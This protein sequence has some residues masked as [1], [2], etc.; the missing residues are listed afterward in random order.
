MSTMNDTERELRELFVETAPRQAPERLRDAIQAGTA[1]LRQRPG[2]LARNRLPHAEPGS[3]RGAVGNQSA[4]LSGTSLRGRAVLIAATT[5]LATAAVGGA[6]FLAGG[7]DGTTTP[8]PTPA[9]SDLPTGTAQLLP[10]GDWLADVGPIPGIGE[11]SGRIHL[12][13]GMPPSTDA[14]IRRADGGYV[15]PSDI[16]SAGPAELRVRATGLAGCSKGDEGHYGF[17]RSADGL[18]LTLTLIEDA[19]APRASTFS[20]TWARSHGAEN[21]GGLGILSAF[22]PAIQVGLPR[23][24]WAVAGVLANETG[25]PMAVELRELGGMTLIAVKNPSGLADP[26]RPE[27]RT[28]VAVTVPVAPTIAAFAAYLSTLPGVA[29][30]TEDGVVGG[31]ATRHVSVTTDRGTSCP[32]QAVAAFAAH[33]TQ[34][35]YWSIGAGDTESIWLVEVGEDLYLLAFRQATPEEEARILSSVQFIDELPTP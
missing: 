34:H 7:R 25:S 8:T 30:T 16:V 29:M 24:Q 19:C 20:R 15:M 33:E 13:I 27:D 12:E 2:W 17:E 14:W 4:S 22:S 21:D 28:G 18:F 23:G 35:I 32:N 9:S 5:V 11:S 1:T 10:W 3:R 6:M 31:Y 26:C